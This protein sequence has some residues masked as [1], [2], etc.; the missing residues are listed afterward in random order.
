[1]A[2]T[3][4]ETT[5]PLEIAGSTAPRRRRRRLRLLAVVFAMA[6]VATACNEHEMRM[7]D[8]VNSARTQ[9]G[10]RALEF[11]TA[12][13]NKA[14]AW[15]QKMAADGRLS[16]SNLAQGNPYNWRSL[17]ENVGMGCGV[18]IDTIHNN[19][20]NSTQHRANILNPNFNYWAVGVFTD[21]RG[22]LWVVQEFMW[23]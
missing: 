3:M 6:I 11:N 8:L 22:C 2:L 15:A 23:L 7:T 21:S 18:S 13:Y 5:A 9:R 17:G 1:M 12:L 10:L 20:M 4:P 19:L 16:H 14:T